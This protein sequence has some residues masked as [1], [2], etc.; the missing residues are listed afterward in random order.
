MNLERFFSKASSGLLRA[1]K[2]AEFSTL[3][4]CTFDL[5]REFR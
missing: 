4:E 5:E 3:K 1:V 2:K